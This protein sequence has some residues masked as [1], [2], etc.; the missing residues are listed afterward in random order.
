MSVG[1]HAGARAIVAAAATINSASVMIQTCSRAVIARSA[2]TM[3]SRRL[4]PEST[5][6]ASARAA[7]ADANGSASGRASASPG[8]R[9]HSA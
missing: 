5:E 6:A 1:T 9:S 3:R 8:I 2:S 7:M 4:R